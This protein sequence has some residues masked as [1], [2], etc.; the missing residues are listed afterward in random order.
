MHVVLAIF[1]EAKEDF[2][3]GYPQDDAAHTGGIV[4]L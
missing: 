2:G 3:G 4:L 1:P